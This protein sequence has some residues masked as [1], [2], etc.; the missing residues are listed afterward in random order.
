MPYHADLKVI[1]RKFQMQL[2]LLHGLKTIVTFLW[3]RCLLQGQHSGTQPVGMKKYEEASLRL[4]YIELHCYK[5][6]HQNT[7]KKCNI[8]MLPGFMATVLNFLWLYG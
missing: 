2:K 1:Y 7:Q 8:L 5:N 6:E 3:L 4:N